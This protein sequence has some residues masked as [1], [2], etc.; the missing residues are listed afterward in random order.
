MNLRNYANENRKNADIL[1]VATAYASGYLPCIAVLSGQIDTTVKR[2]YQ[3]AKC[4]VLTG[5]V[6][7]NDPL[8]STYDFARMVI[9]YDLA[10]FFERNKQILQKEINQV[11]EALLTP[12]S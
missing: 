4:L 8:T 2:R 10:A 5:T 12:T 3:A 1:N 9:G 6:G 7:L 11:L